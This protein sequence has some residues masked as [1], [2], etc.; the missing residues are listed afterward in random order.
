MNN[1][2]QYLSYPR[3]GELKVEREATSDTQRDLRDR[4]LTTARVRE[5]RASRCGEL[6]A[7]YRRAQAIRG[8]L[9]DL[10]ECLDEKVS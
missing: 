6:D 3:L 9:T 1:Q 10:I 8:Y 7:A 2:F 5:S 4:L